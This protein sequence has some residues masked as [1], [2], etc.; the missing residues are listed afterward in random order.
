MKQHILTIILKEENRGIEEV[1]LGILCTLFIIVSFFAEKFNSTIIAFFLFFY[2]LF[3]AIVLP[4][5]SMKVESSLTDRESSNV[6][7]GIMCFVVIFSHYH[8]YFDPGI[9]KAFNP[10]GY[11]G[12]SFFLFCSGYG[13]NINYFEGGKSLKHFCNRHFIKIIV[14]YW[15]SLAII[16][17]INIICKYNIEIS[18]LVSSIFTLNSILP[19]AWYITVIL[20]WYTLFYLIMLIPIKENSKRIILNISLI[21]ITIIILVFN[22]P[23][24]YYKTLL[25]LM[26]G[27]NYRCLSHLK[28]TLLLFIGFLISL[29]VLHKWGGVRR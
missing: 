26:L 20:A 16:L 18:G 27:F 8:Y 12:V 10:F 23:S 3:F 6:L 5:S 24:Y 15:I 11:L 1:A 29:C 22:L 19:F 9:L 13:L 28:H 21:I 7:R 17:C 14:P 25:C 2:L 4:N